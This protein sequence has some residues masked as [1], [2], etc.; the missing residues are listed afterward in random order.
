MTTEARFQAIDHLIRL[1]KII[2]SSPIF[3]LMIVDIYLT[4]NTKKQITF[5]VTISKTVKK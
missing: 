3:F 4:L 1:L 2:F 5:I